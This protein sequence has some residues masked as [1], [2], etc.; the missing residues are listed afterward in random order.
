MRDG[1]QEKIREHMVKRQHEKVNADPDQRFDG[2]LRIAVAVT[3]VASCAR[4]H[5]IS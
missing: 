4:V 2:D 1:M 5:G 3:L